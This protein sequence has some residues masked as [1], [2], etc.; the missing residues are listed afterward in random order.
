MVWWLIGDANQAPTHLWS[1][2]D[3]CDETVP[4]EQAW[5]HYQTPKP[6]SRQFPPKNEKHEKT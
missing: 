2:E 5:K 4:A 6:E 3:S 1:Q